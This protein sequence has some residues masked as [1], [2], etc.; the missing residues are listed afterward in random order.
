MVRDF[1]KKIDEISSN[2]NIKR[3]KELN[4]ELNEQFF[5]PMEIAYY[6]SSMFTPISKSEIEFMDVGAGLGN[7]TAAF[8]V[9]VCEWRK[10]P[11]KIRVTLVEIDSTIID[12]L[13][14]NMELCVD[15]C[16]K[17]KIQIEFIFKNKDFIDQTVKELKNNSVLHYDYIIL[18]PPYKKLS[19][20]TIDKRLLSSVGID[21]PNYYAAFVSLA[22]RL[23]K[24]KGQL[25]C[26]I[27][28]S[29]CNG[30]YFKG[31]RMDILNNVKIERIH[32]FESR[33]DLF[34]DDVLQ[35]TLIMVLA[36]N[37][38]RLNDTVL[39]SDSITDDFSTVQCLK[40]K[41]DNIVFPYDTEKIIRIIKEND[42][43]IVERMHS[44]PCTL[45]DLDLTVS[46]GPVVDFREK[47]GL[48][49]FDGT[50]FSVPIIYPE[51]F[52]KGFI[53]WPIIGKKPGFLIEDVSNVKK[54]RPPGIYV[55]VKRMSSK[56]EKR[57]IIAVVYDSEFVSSG[58]VAFDNKVNY[59][60]CKKKGIVNRSVA[61]GL[62]VYLN[63]SLVDFYFRTFS[64]ST[65]VNVADLK[66][67]R[68]PTLE[69]LE[70]MGSAYGEELPVQ[71]IID[72][73]VNNEL[74]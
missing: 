7:L 12:E 59:F 36:K 8:I 66:S 37:R 41:F 34:Y 35:E 28:R 51:N 5:T 73:I 23:L 68:Y 40:K 6:M 9:S 25:V 58:R 29:F 38:Q 14:A 67:L 42:L 54:L 3:S 52:S 30:Q 21:V 26:I 31:F 11:K 17:N 44:L 69:I 50:L 22:H 16:K 43:A 18:N 1:L 32:L 2:T 48:L 19:T 63:S 46:T 15:L 47:E 61:K 62:S 4:K 74:F 60:H 72:E 39:I 53:E 33:N 65:Q 71:E 24:D 10:K 55:L 45:E 13:K 27:P 57:R 20:N 70:K 56:E 64:G 49:R